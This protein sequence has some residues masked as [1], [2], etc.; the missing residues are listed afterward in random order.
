MKSITGVEIKER[1]PDKIIQIADEVVNIDLTIEELIDRLNEGKIYDK[2]KVSTALQNFFQKDK[3]LQ[4]RDLAL[5]EVSRQVERKIVREIPQLQ[6]G[7][8]NS[9]LTCISSNNKSAAKLIRRS[10]RLASFYNSKWFVVYVETPK[11]SP[12]K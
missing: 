1:V 9:L 10:S 4:L 3:L 5:K 12:P 11:E 2:S 6:R 8:I 7:K